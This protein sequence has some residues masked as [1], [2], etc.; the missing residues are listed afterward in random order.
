MLS[1]AYFRRGLA[2]ECL[3][4]LAEAKEDM[5]RLREL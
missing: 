4:K 2:Y 1:K 5:L 3:E